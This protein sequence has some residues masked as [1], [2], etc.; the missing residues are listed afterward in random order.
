MAASYSA[1][2]EVDIKLVFSSCKSSSAGIK[3][4]HAVASVL[5]FLYRRA[6]RFYLHAHLHAD[7]SIQYFT[8]AFQ[9][10]RRDKRTSRTKT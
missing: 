9:R 3:I 4:F 8:L 10:V 6:A 5:M 7:F 2:V 1:A